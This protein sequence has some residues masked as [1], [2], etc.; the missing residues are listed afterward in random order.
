MNR[1]AWPTGIVVKM[2]HPG[3]KFSERVE[4]L[5]GREVLKNETLQTLTKELV[6]KAPKAVAFIGPDP[7]GAVH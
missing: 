4:E 3:Q 1:G 5:L 6:L 7:T 2:S